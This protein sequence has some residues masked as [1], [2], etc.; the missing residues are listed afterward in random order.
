MIRPIQ[1]TRRDLPAHRRRTWGGSVLEAAII[2]PILVSLAFGMTEFSYF[3]FVKHTLEGAA[4]EGARNA[5]TPS[6][7]NSTATA[8]VTAALTA[9][10]GTGW[11]AT[12]VFQDITAGTTLSAGNWSAVPAGDA[13]QVTLSCTWST[14]GVRPLG[15]IPASKQVIGIC[16]MRKE[17]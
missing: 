4:R 7:T 12:T 13:I 1:I 9:A 16:V 6:S 2:I 8:A 10:G 11:G 15:I 5:I 14:V 17:G 3:F